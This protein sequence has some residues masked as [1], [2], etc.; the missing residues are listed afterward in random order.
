MEASLVN[1]QVNEILNGL[2]LP[3]AEE[4]S[5]VP[6]DKLAEIYKICL[7][8]VAVCESNNGIG[9]A[10]V[11]VGIPY[12]FFVIKGNKNYKKNNHDTYGYFLN[13][14]YELNF[15]NS[16][17]YNTEKVLSLEGCLSLRSIDGRLRHYQ[18]ERYRSIIL[19]GY[20][21]YDDTKLDLVKI[22]NEPIDGFEAVVFQHEIDHGHG[23]LISDFGQE[24]F[25]YK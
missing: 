21:L 17:N 3:K 23:K 7:K 13:C 25:M 6:L 16:D 10:A 22:D 9:L 4:I 14:K 8:M 5:Q 2:Q 19:N 24:V 1:Y 12:N 18:V 20:R 11:Q 15:Y